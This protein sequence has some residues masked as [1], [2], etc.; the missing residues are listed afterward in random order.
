MRNKAGF[1]M[2]ELM[3][4]IGIIAI[5]SAIVTPNLIGWYQHQGLRSAV[6][7]L[8][9]NLQ[10]AKLAAVKQNQNCSVNFNTG[11]GSY[12]I[13]CI[14]TAVS[15]GTYSG[16]VVFGG[17]G[18]ETTDSQITYSSRGFT[19]NGQSVY[20]TNSDNSAYYR[21]QVLASGGVSTTKLE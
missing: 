12:N 10:L 3:V 11:A 13:P 6:V 7:E 18:G 19:L 2:L 1:S 4:V 15:L 16:G 9:S 8:Q 17:P 14:G 5:L 20:L 21:I